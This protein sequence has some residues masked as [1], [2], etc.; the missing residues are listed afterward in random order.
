MRI[1]INASFLDEQPCGVG[2]YTQEVLRHLS[3]MAAFSEHQVDVFSPVFPSGMEDHFRWI[4]LS[5]RFRRSVHQHHNALHR[6]LW[7]AFAFSRIARTYDVVYAP[8]PNTGLIPGQIITIHDL[9]A[10]EYPRQHRLQFLFYRFYLPKLLHRAHE[11]IA[12]SNTTR[13]ALI[14]HYSIPDSKIRVIHNGF[15]EFPNTG[16]LP[17]ELSS[18]PYVLCVG[19]SLPHKNI[20]VVMRALTNTPLH[21][22]ITGRPAPFYESHLR[23]LAEELGLAQRIHWLGYCSTDLLR[24]LYQNA[25]ALAYP[26]LQEGFGL[27]ILEAQNLGCPVIAANTSS[28]PE[29]AG[30]GAILLDPFD[31]GSW[32]KALLA[33]YQPDYRTLLLKKGKENCRLFS[34]QRT[35]SEIAQTILENSRSRNM[36]SKSDSS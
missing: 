26:S 12:V 17:L 6:H 4:P 35:A 28:L 21:L 13:H 9:I 27:P 10:L 2:I 30:Q 15:S 24:T 19:V 5:R 14:H 23:T 11:I 18:N 16:M 31:S 8:S 29:I 33:L 1:A 20:E 25:H 3:R 22:I 32:A 36:T 7:N 34:W